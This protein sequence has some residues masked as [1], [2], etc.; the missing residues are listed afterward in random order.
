MITLRTDLHREH[1]HSFD[2]ELGSVFLMISMMKL[3]IVHTQST[4]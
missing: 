4:M 1:S 3:Y 2:H